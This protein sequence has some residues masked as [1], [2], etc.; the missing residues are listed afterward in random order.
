MHIWEHQIAKLVRRRII[1]ISCNYVQMC[2]LQ[3]AYET[4][5]DIITKQYQIQWNLS[6][7][8]TPN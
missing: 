3:H 2:V 1:H 5:I 8:D 7:K 6:I 4:Q